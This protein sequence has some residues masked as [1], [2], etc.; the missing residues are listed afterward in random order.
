[1]KDIKYWERR[2]RSNTQP[3]AA[4]D[5]KLLLGSVFTELERLNEEIQSM[6]SKR[7]RSSSKKLEARSDSDVDSSG[8]A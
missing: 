4:G 6:G 3:L 8:D 5:L 7:S 1:M 2:V